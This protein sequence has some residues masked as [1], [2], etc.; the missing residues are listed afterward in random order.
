V[1]NKLAE[2]GFKAVR[3]FIT[4]IP[5]NSKG[6]CSVSLPDVENPVGVFDDT[7][8]V[9]VDKLMSELVS[10]SMKLIIAMHDR[11]SLGTWQRDAYV[12]KYNLP[13]DPALNGEYVKHR[14]NVAQELA[15]LT[16]AVH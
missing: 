9:R 13:I 14:S 8:L 6:S 7:Q 16:F 15:K 5:A 11:Y 2:A 1:V 4:Q 10:K 12:D 3:I